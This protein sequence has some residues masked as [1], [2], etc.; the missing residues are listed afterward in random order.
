MRNFASFLNESVGSGD[1]QRESAKIVEFLKNKIGQDYVELDGQNYTNTNGTYFGFLYVSKTDNSAIRINWEGNTFHS[2]NFWLDWDYATDPAKEIFVKDAVPGKSSFSKILPDIANILKDINSFDDGSNEEEKEKEED[3]PVDESVLTER[4]VEFDG[5]IFTTKNDLVIQL[6][7]EEKT[8]SEI[9]RATML[10]KE[11]IKSILAKYLYSKGGSVSE[12]GKALNADN[13]LVRTY[14]GSPDAE[15]T[16][17]TFNENIE[18]MAGL[19]ETIV[20]NK[21]VKKGEAQ[22]EEVEYADPD[23]VFDELTNYVT[24]CANKLLPSLL[25][26]GQDKIGKTYNVEKVLNGIG[27]K[28]ETWILIKGKPTAETIFT[29]IWNN[30]DKVIVFNDCD[31]IFKDPDSLNIVKAALVSNTTRD[32]DW[33]GG[34]TGFVNTDDLDDNVEIEERCQTWS[35]EHKGKEGIPSH[36]KFEGTVVFITDNTKA[37][38]FKKEP[39]FVAKCTCFD[40]VLNAQNPLVRMETILPYLKIY[41]ATNSKGTDGKEITNEDLKYEVLDFINSDAFLKNPKVRGKQISFRIFDE[42]YKLRYAE[43]ENWEKL[44][45]S[46]N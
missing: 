7:E 39:E 14:V 23:L 15:A 45:L 30:R 4:K 26:T 38:L 20:M 25:V 32:I 21:F 28:D 10:N 2:I 46:C 29:T 41:K 31:S 17:I 13:N 19:K 22:L 11:Q 18:I 3:K 43:L 8:L 34:E 9:M 37:E 40:L 33:I 35:D 16:N 1:I 5:K 36:F 6:Y 44:A 12:I 24:M 42:I 27:K